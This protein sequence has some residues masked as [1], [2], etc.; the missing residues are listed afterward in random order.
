[1][2]VLASIVTMAPFSIDA[3][4]PAFPTI[5]VDLNSA[6]SD[7]QMTLAAFLMGL[8][9]G[10]LF[11]GSL[12]DAVGRRKVL[13]WGLLGFFIMSVACAAAPNIETLIISRFLQ[14][15]FV[16]ASLTTG[17][18]LLSDIYTGDELSKKSSIIM[19][20]M[21]VAPMIAPIFGALIT[22]GLGWRYIFWLLA[23][24]S[25]FLAIGSFKVVPETL[26]AQQRV[27]LEVRRYIQ[28]YFELLK[29]PLILTHLLAALFVS[30]SFF[31]YLSAT[32][33]IYIN[34]FGMSE[35]Q[36]SY[37]FA[38][39]AI[40]AVAGNW[41]NMTLIEK[42]GYKCL[43]SWQGATIIVIGLAMLLGVFGDLRWVIYIAGFLLMAS[44]H[45]ISTNSTT[46]VLDDSPNSR[47]AASAIMLAGRFGGGMFGV[48]CIGW[49]HGT[50]IIQY[51][52]ILSIFCVLSGCFAIIGLR[53]LSN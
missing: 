40:V 38:I 2:V 28:S 53:A 5:S 15:A 25:V 29:R 8:A 3:Y 27:P 41:L 39:G 36:F 42:F 33:F 6:E 34:Q 48:A 47:G 4:L 18:A 23:A 20:L 13:L 30:A 11:F 19:L 49:F 46:G 12:S 26:A 21:S 9:L 10:P 35:V 50:D 52:I 32:P 37:L 45:V 43:L 17:T 16:A 44:M 24:F 22:N 14:A 1:M 7:V 51:G 31:A